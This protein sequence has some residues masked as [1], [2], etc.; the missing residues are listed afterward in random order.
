MTQSKTAKIAPIDFSKFF[1]SNSA[2]GVAE[3][4]FYAFREG[5]R[6]EV[7]KDRIVKFTKFCE[8]ENEPTRLYD[9]AVSLHQGAMNMAGKYFNGLIAYGFQ[10]FFS[11]WEV[12]VEQKVKQGLKRDIDQLVCL[13]K[14]QVYI[15]ATTSPQE[16][17][18]GTFPK[19]YDDVV[20]YRR[21]NGITDDFHFIGVF[22][23]RKPRCSLEASI[24]T[25]RTLQTLMPQG[26]QIL[27]L[28]DKDHVA[29]ALS[30]LL[31]RF[32]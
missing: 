16:R 12:Q 31:H 19:E 30:S 1:H 28:H 6:K 23:E 25:R 2:Q 10:Y 9:G 8:Q 14:G 15:S 21:V 26:V 17:K 5:I 7:R 22:G 20:S 32:V 4:L 18:N 3:S 11:P 13:P 27:C 24:E 29:T